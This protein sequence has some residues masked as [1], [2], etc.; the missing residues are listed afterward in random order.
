MGH[1]A[2]YAYTNK[3]ESFFPGLHRALMRQRSNL[4]LT[5]SF[6]ISMMNETNDN[7]P[8]MRGRLDYTNSVLREQNPY[9]DAF[10]GTTFWEA[11]FEGW[12]DART[13]TEAIHKPLK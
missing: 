12:D 7:D 3:A 4:R 13:E 6:E 10:Y 11:W 2:E 9:D 5:E 8:H 1:S